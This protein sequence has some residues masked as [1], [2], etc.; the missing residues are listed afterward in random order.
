MSKNIQVKN[1]KIT[2]AKKPL[3]T[4]KYEIEIRA[5]TKEDALEQAYSLIGSKH[6]IQRLQLEVENVK[7]IPDQKLKSPILRE[8]ALNDETKLPV[9]K[10]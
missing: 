9:S 3:K 6:R 5:M 10:K 7:E 8:L 1:Y 4:Q 2:F